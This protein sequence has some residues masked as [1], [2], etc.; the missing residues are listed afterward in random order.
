VHRLPEVFSRL[1]PE[2]DAELRSV[3]AERRS[4]MYDMI[5]YHLGW[6]DRSGRPD[7]S[8]RGKA[9]RPTM[10]LLACQA[11][12]GDYRTALPAA[13]AIE[14]VHNYSLIHDDVQD[15]DTERRHRPTVWSIWGKPQAIN[16]GTAM[17]MLANA[18]LRRLTSDPSKQSH[19]QL[20]VDEATISLIEGQYLDI[21]YENRLDITPDEYLTMIG[22]KT[23]ALLGCALETGA[24]LG[25]DDVA[26]TRALG[27][28]GRDIGLAFQIRDDILGIWGESAETGKPSCNDIRRRKK[29]LPVVIAFQRTSGAERIRIRGLYEGGPLGESGVGEVMS[30]LEAVDAR[31]E[32]ETLQRSFARRAQD[33]VRQLCLEPGPARDLED[34]VRFLDC[35]TF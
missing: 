18:A 8:G 4:P 10:C 31:K 21:S 5:R 12:G 20:L 27:K 7:E 11:V 22:G 13:A 16:A 2:I 33:A 29:T 14:L 6:I 1:Q 9:V 32:S 3:L 30:I 35:R 28:F 19:I 24:E 23:A 26:C 34:V 25:T 17:R 15:D